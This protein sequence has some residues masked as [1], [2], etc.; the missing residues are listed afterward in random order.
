MIVDTESRGFSAPGFPHET[1]SRPFYTSEL[2]GNVGP[3]LNTTT[4][5]NKKEK[6]WHH[7]LLDL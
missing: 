5:E 2:M 7:V 3:H 6:L 1:L 4:G